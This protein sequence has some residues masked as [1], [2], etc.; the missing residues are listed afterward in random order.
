MRTTRRTLLV[1]VVL[2]LVLP[3]AATAGAGPSKPAPV[4]PVYYQVEL[5]LT[6]DSGL[7]T[8]C[9]GPITMEF[10]N[11]GYKAVRPTDPADPGPELAI[12]ADAGMTWSR[13]RPTESSG[14]FSGECHGRQ[15]NPL[16]PAW[17]AILQITADRAGN[18]TGLV[19][20]FDYYATQTT[21]K[22]N[23]VRIEAL[24][25]LTLRSLC[26]PIDPEYA[27]CQE[28]EATETAPGSGVYEVSGTFTLYRWYPAGSPNPEFQG[29]SF[30]EFT[31]TFEP[32]P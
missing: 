28:F 8:T 19:W 26:D 22:N 21:Y 25:W 2:A 24:E 23:R 15:I 32:V 11:Y 14:T 13:H 20:H 10:G 5:T 31:M 30:F 3:L 27:D 4:K 9:P 6:G 29:S 18:P 1:L 17:P 12:T 7:A 16:P